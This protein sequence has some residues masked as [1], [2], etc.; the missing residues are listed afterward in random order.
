MKKINYYLIALVAAIGCVFTSCSDEE[1][2]L[3]RAVLAS[4]DIL[5]YEALPEGPQIITVTSDADWVS[6]APEWVTISPASGHAGQTEVEISVSENTRDAAVDNPRKTTIQFK[7][8]NLWSIASV[9]VRQDGD[10][11]RDPVDYTI[12]AMEAAEDE[13]VVRLP[14][15]IVTTVTGNGFIATDGTDYVYV[16]EPAISVSVGKKVSI[17]GEKFT[18]E[19]KMAYVL[20]ERMTDEGT[21]AVP[22]KTPVDITSTLDKTNGKKYQYVTLTGD[23]DGTAITVGEM[24]CKAYPVDAPQSLELGKLGGHKIKVTG[25]FAGMA[26]P[27]VNIIPAEIEDL[28][29]NEVIYFFDDF[30]WL[31]PW[32]AAGK[33]GNGSPSAGDTIGDNNESAE[34]PQISAKGMVV[35]GITAEKAMLDKGYSFYRVTPDSDN[36]GECIYLNR[37]YLKFGKTG[38]QAG[39]CF[40]SIDVPSGESVVMEFDWSVQR[41]GNGNFDPVTLYVLVDNNGTETEFEIPTHT[42]AQN[43]AFKWIHVEVDLS[44]VTISKDSKISLKQREWKLTTANRWFLDNVKFKQA[45]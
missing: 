19:I 39:I 25:Y 2:N 8:R 16:K 13:T 30:E 10:K 5:E 1:T 36:A 45:K 4:V 11:F 12:E 41:K 29:V 21:A 38:F 7:G 35:D 22:E 18:D 44:S 23:F 32:A 33:N 28:G 3:S 17:V 26:S 24:T 9:I 40:P 20:G 37:N 27:V 14:N 42:F 43:D 15:M 34:S 31:A 6:E